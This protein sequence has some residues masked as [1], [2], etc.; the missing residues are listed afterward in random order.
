MSQR[1]VAEVLTSEYKKAAHK[2]PQYIGV[3]TTSNI[4]DVTFRT[5]E[6][7]PQFVVHHQIVLP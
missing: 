3:S 7:V 5:E 4:V 2:I 6:F 1:R